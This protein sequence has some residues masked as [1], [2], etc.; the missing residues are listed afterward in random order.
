MPGLELQSGRGS[1]TIALPSRRMANSFG[2]APSQRARRRQCAQSC[3]STDRLEHQMNPTCGRGPSKFTVRQLG[4]TWR[5]DL[6]V[7]PAH[8][9]SNRN[10]EYP[11]FPI[12]QCR[13]RDRLAVVEPRQAP[14]ELSAHAPAF[15]ARPRAPPLHPPQSQFRSA[16]NAMRRPSGGCPRRADEACLRPAAGSVRRHPRASRFPPVRVSRKRTAGN[17]DHTAS[18]TDP[19]VGDFNTSRRRRLIS[20]AVRDRQP[21]ECRHRPHDRRR[22]A[23]EIGT[24]CSDS[25]TIRFPPETASQTWCILER[26]DPGAGHRRFS[27]IKQSAPVNGS[28]MGNP[29]GVVGH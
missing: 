20:H 12:V 14:R 7:A 16:V 18:G 13:H 6:S 10:L 8:R 22:R 1:T 19:V 4:F 23:K 28:R 21:P 29:R 24:H 25:Y 5:N 3:R 27:S 26:A 2:A 11:G 15:A 17:P 9:P